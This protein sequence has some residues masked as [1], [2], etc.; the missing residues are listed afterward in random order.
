VIDL[1]P[2]TKTL[3]CI[4]S[5][6]VGK[7]T[8][9]ATVAVGKAHEGLKVLVLTI[10]PSLRL[11]QALGMKADGQI[12]DLTTAQMGQKNGKLFAC[13]IQHEKAFHDFIVK[14]SD[15]KLS[16]TEIE[17]L[18]SNK[19]YKQ[20]STKLSGS[21]EFT[22]LFKLNQFV[23]SGDYDLVILDT[24]PAQHTWQFLKAPEKLSHLFNE[25]VAS[26]FRDP[27]QADMGFFKKV[28]NIGTK[29]VLKALESLT[30][31]DFI[32]EL[33]LFFL[34]IQ[35]WQGPLEKQVMDCHKILTSKTTEFALVTM[36]DP[37]R[38]V[39][40]QKIS[41]EIH[42]EGYNLTMLIINKVPAWFKSSMDNNIS[43]SSNKL[44]NLSSY[45]QKIASAI[46]DNQPRLSSAQFKSQLKIYKCPEV[47]QNDL[48]EKKLFEIYLQIQPSV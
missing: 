40:C 28:I 42:Q 2:T 9:A 17:K 47:S 21:Q 39:E 23:N 31:A 32:K 8:F 37:S 27:R 35:N 33:S 3:I 41:Q 44:Q 14:A 36:L 10:D 5:G 45:Y 18:T 15:Q 38:V 48:H 4:G 22:S 13:V 34:A 12:Y 7:T 29:Q 16:A 26:W 30:G 25:G 43:F 6:G 46:K 20:L 11:A 1:K 19:L 24:P